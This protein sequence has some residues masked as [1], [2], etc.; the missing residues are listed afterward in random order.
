MSNDQVPTINNDD[1][2]AEKLPTVREIRRIPEFQPLRPKQLRFIVGLLRSN[3]IVEEASRKCGVGWRNHYYWLSK[4][5]IYKQAV[6]KVTAMLG[7]L[8][9]ATMLDHALAGREAP[10]IYQ[11]KITGVQREINAQERIALLRG[12]KPQYRDNFQLNSIT[13]P[14]QINVIYHSSIQP[15]VIGPA[16][17]ADDRAASAIDVSNDGSESAD[18]DER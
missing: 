18:D 11:G 12:L 1:L 6:E 16:A 10:I 17:P 5:E 4:D 15:K 3:L 8:L 9:E 7:D 14:T 13:G 2:R